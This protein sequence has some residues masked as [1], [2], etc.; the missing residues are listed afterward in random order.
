MLLLYRTHDRALLLVGILVYAA[1]WKSS[2]TTSYYYS[3]VNKQEAALTL[4]KQHGRCRTVKGEPDIFLSSANPRPRPLFPLGMVLWWALA[5]P[6]S[7]SSSFSRCTHIKGKPQNC[8]SS[9]GQGHI[10][11]SYGCDFM[12]G[13]G[14]P[15]PYTKF[16]VASFSHYVNIEGETPKFWRAPLAQHHA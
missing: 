15:K 2:E 6:S 12:M 10:N 7:M 14:K 9:S 11:F 8:G 1:M 5:N 16:E 3:D 13:L 4:R